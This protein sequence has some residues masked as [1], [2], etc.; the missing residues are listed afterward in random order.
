VLIPR[1]ETELMAERAIGILQKEM[2][3]GEQ[4][5]T[6]LDCCTGSGCIALSLAREIPRL[7]VIGSDISQDALCYAELNAAAQ[8]VRNVAFIRGDLFGHFKERVFD[9]VISNPP[10]IRTDDIQALQPEIRS[11]EPHRALDGGPDGLRY[12]R[13]IAS[14]AKAVMKKGAILMVEAADDE[15]GD[16]YAMLR[17]EGYA[18]IEIIKDYAGLQRIIQATWIS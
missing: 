11:W 12:Y 6:V 15:A 7:Q 13:T 10:Y 8:A 4:R 5:I 14:Q 17:D 9:F 2:H 16:I 3:S 1:P 18:D